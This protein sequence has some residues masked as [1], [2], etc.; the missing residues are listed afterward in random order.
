MI[1]DHFAQKA[2]DLAVQNLRE[3]SCSGSARRK[4]MSTSPI[5]SVLLRRICCRLLKSLMSAARSAPYSI[6]SLN[7]FCDEYSTT[8]KRR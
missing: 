2:A 8:K 1:A 6:F 7:I 4:T 3:H 5:T